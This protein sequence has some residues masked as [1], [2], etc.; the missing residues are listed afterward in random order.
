MN[1]ESKYFLILCL[2][3]NN[4]NQLI[5]AKINEGKITDVKRMLTIGANLLTYT[6]NLTQVAN[7]YCS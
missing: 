6:V 3:L 7:K 5:A 1:K 4:D 2:F